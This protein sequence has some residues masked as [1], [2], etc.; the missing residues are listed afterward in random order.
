MADRSRQRNLRRGARKPIA[1][2]S[3]LS[4]FRRPSHVGA[5]LPGPRWGVILTSGAALDQRRSSRRSVR[6]ESP[7]CSDRTIVK[8]GAKASSKPAS[9]Y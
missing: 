6:P 9:V 7:S 5:A 1:R 2:N 8:K 3:A 4:E